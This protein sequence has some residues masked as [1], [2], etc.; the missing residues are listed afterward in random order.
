LIQDTYVE[1]AGMMG[2]KE[3]EL[4]MKKKVTFAKANGLKL[5]VITPKDVDNLEKI[6]SEFV[7]S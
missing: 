2:V 7:K 4:K 5:I 3:Y 1:F 6:F